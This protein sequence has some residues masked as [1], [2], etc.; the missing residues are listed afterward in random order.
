MINEQALRATL[1][2]MVKQA[3][4]N[5]QL[6]STLGAEVIA[7][8]ETVSALDP[9]FGEVLAQKRKEEAP[10]TARVDSAALEEYDALLRRLVAGE[11][12]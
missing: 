3:R 9:T 11:V 4:Y 5:Y 6:I 8:R 12:C 2:L 1:L 10:L 7:L